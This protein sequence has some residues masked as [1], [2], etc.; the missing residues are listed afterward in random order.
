MCA[1][2]T[3]QCTVLQVTQRQNSTPL[4]HNRCLET[5][6]LSQDKASRAQWMEHV[7][8]PVSCSI[9]NENTVGGSYIG[10]VV[11]VSTQHAKSE[12]NGCR[13]RERHVENAEVLEIWKFGSLDFFCG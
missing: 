6:L 7:L 1:I 9:V 12:V 11:H 8:C 4:L 3:N 2:N 10:C 5:H 13:E